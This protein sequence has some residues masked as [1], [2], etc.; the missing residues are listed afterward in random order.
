MNATAVQQHRTIHD[1][2]AASAVNP[3]FL[4]PI[5]GQQLIK[6]HWGVGQGIC[7]SVSTNRKRGKKVHDAGRARDKFTRSS[8]Y[9]LH[10]VLA[11]VST[12]SLFQGI[13]MTFN[14]PQSNIEDTLN[15]T[16]F[17]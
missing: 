17:L 8:F 16:F 4:D 13:L 6:V 7:N 1:P 11:H 3:R 10:I 9:I 14:F 5:A 2:T 15:K 12:W